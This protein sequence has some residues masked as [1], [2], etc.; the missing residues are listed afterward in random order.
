MLLLAWLGRLTSPLCACLRSLLWESGPGPFFILRVPANRER[1]RERERERD[2]EQETEM[3]MGPMSGS[4]TCLK[5]FL[6]ADVL[7]E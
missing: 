7:V 1:E 4:R 5:A 3:E 2:G 6:V